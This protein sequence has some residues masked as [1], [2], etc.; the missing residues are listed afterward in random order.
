LDGRDHKRLD[1]GVFRETVVDYL[2]D[3]AAGAWVEVFRRSNR[4]TV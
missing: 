1:Q 4:E 3:K 2:T